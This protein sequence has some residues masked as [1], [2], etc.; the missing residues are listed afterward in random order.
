PSLRF[1]TFAQKADWQNG[2]AANFVGRFATSPIRQSGTGNPK[3][4]RTL[5]SLKHESVFNKNTGVRN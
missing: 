1:G 4:K 3:R 2:F 5:E